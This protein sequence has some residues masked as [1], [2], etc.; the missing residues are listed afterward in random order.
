MPSKVHK[1]T[2]QELYD[3]VWLEPMRTLAKRL[4][5]SDVGLAKACK[6]Y[7]IPRPPRGYWAK[8]KAG[9]KIPR[10]SLPPR[11]LGMSNEIKIGG[12][13]WWQESL[14]DEKI[15][16]STPK[17]PVFE[18]DISDVEKRV[19]VMVKPVPAARSLAKAH[20]I[21][22]KLLQADEERREKQRQSSYSFSWDAPIFDDPFEKRRLCVLSAI[23]IALERYGMRPSLGGKEARELS[24]KVGDQDVCFILDATS[25]K[26]DSRH[27][28]SIRTRGTSNKLRLVFPN[29]RSSSGIR[30]SWEDSKGLPLEKQLRDIVTTLIVTGE[31]NYRE[32]RQGHYEWM[33]ERKA[34]LQE[35]ERKRREENAR[36]E[37]E[38]IIQL[39]KERVERLLGDATALRQAA[40]IRSYVEAVRTLCA[41]EGKDIP[42]KKMGAWVSWAQAQVDRIDPVRSGRFLKSMQ[43]REELVD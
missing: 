19:R 35:E 40:D 18:E 33:V 7:D 15:L 13:H 8:L 20:K 9:K 3:L 10:Q 38:R 37:R 39:E 11:G 42:S 36:K 28:A 4:G 30:N 23:F 1:F 17:P 41:T 21:I 16:N 43:D 26:H 29:W 22:G 31:R 6:R 32:G 25:Q 2:R 27:E 34:R 24:V 12:R 5:R 14:S